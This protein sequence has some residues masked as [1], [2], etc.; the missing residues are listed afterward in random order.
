MEQD[1]KVGNIRRAPESA[2]HEG[3]EQRSGKESVQVT[4]WFFYD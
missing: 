2:P 3:G 4:I 1:Q